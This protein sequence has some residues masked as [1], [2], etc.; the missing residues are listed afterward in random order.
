MG[1][2]APDQDRLSTKV[3]GRMPALNDD[4]CLCKCSPPPRLINSQTNFRE[5]V[6][7]TSWTSIKGRI[8]SQA[9]QQNYI[10]ENNNKAV[11]EVRLNNGYYF[12]VQGLFDRQITYG[13]GN[14]DSLY[15]FSH[16]K[17]SNNYVGLKKLNIS[18][19][20]FVKIAKTV[21][22]ESS[23]FRVN[24]ISEEL[25]KEMFAIAY[26]IHTNPKATAYGEHS[27]LARIFANT[28][29]DKRNGTKMMLAVAAV[30]NTQI[31]G[32]DYSYGATN[33]DG[34]EQATV[35]PSNFKGRSLNGF[36]AHKNTWGWDISQEHY[37]KWKAFIGHKFVDVV[38][39][40]P[41]TTGINKG[42]IR[43]K[44]T[45]VYLGT[46]FWKVS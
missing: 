36:E 26:V 46:I 23:A 41:A 21:Y 43:A 2:I 8:D 25:A 7:N 33:W 35:F 9:L 4:L 10:A 16:K 34:M 29:P 28:T 42:R 5:V 13:V 37:D 15:V 11:S 38:R 20:E 3:N 19:P 40:H 17:A 12:N 1:K 44:S 39:I 14:K 32:Y 45:A 18:Y 22:E 27:E 31:G 24:K 6:E 30:I